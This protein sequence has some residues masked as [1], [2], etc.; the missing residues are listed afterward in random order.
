MVLE[1][2]RLERLFAIAPQKWRVILSYTEFAAGD[3]ALA[4][5]RLPL[6]ALSTYFSP[7][8]RRRLPTDHQLAPAD[9]EAIHPKAAGIK[10]ISEG[11]DLCA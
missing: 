4:V 9:R 10:R 6:H 3:G 8:R 7:S 1:T 2:V 11:G 5:E